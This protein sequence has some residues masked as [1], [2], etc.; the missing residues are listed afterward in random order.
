MRN[1]LLI[2]LTVLLFANC[3]QIKKE[4]MFKDDIEFL[5]NIEGLE[6]LSSGNSK[7]AVSGILQGR[8]FTSSSKGMEGISYGYFNK[9]LILKEEYKNNLTAMGGEGRLIFAP[10]VGKY[11]TFFAPNT[12]QTAETIGPSK[13]MKSKRFIVESKT[14]KS[15]VCSSTMNILNANNYTFNI[16]VKR[17][18]SILSSEEIKNELNIAYNNVS[19]VAFKVESWVKNIDSIQWSKQ[20]GLLSIWDLACVKTTPKTIVIIPTKNKLDSV[21]NYF[22]PLTKERIKIE[23]ET[24]F[25]K[26]DANYMNKIGIQPENVKNV[27]GSYSPELSLLTICTFNF[28]ENEELYANCVWGHTKPYKGDVINIFNGE[29]NSAEDR[30]WPFYELETLSAQSEL[31]PN[32]ELYHS[33]TIFHFEGSKYALDVISK[34]LL[35]VALTEINI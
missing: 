20:N 19:E 2:I 10:E 28:V 22:T 18:V 8:V 31:K 7:I 14:D 6:I 35:G 33:Q 9:N 12:P 30:N 29:V 1:L 5:K 23:N 17:K 4:T 24:V 32:E 15:I 21:T 34:K 26:A 3:N 16:D 11:A 13:D 27:F 25:Y